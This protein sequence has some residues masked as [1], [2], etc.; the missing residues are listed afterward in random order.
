MSATSAGAIK[1]YIET[2][3]LGLPVFRDRAPDNQAL[4]Y[5]TITEAISIVPEPAFNSY[6]DPDGHV[7]ELAQVDLWQQWR[8]EGGGVAENYSLPDALT[9]ALDG[10]RTTTAPTWVGGMTVT[11][12]V[13]L[14]EL[15]INTVHVAIT[16]EIRRTLTPI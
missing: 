3:G 11:G 10:R 13:R 2:L 6:D 12:V 16:V 4:P 7:R 15:D 9:K 8:H 1:A 5:I 14:L